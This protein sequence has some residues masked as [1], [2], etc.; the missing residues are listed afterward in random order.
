MGQNPRSSAFLTAEQTV[1]RSADVMVDYLDS[2]IQWVITILRCLVFRKAERT[3][4]H[5]V[6][7]LE[8]L[9]VYPMDLTKETRWDPR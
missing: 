3:A 8:Q 6:P 5:W 2:M 9:M 4:L 1:L 7:D